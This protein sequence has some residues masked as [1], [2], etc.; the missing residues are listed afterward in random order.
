MTLIWGFDFGEANGIALGEFSD[1]TP[2]AILDARIV[3][4]GLIGFVE[5]WE[6]GPFAPIWQCGDEVIVAEKFKPI[7]GKATVD[8]SGIPQEGALYALMQRENP[9]WKPHWQTAD[10]KQKAGWYDA[11]LKEHGLWKTGS[12][13]NW[14]DGRDAND[15]IIHSLE[16]L[17]RIEHRPTLEK[18]FKGGELG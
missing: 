12:D 14:K 3:P 18:Y 16:Y 7:P 6:D 15:A 1:D 4:G 10:A 5:W 9:A 2:Y 11:I 8:I 17:R 13:V